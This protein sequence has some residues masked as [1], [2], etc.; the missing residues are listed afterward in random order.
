MIDSLSFTLIC[1]AYLVW[2]AWRVFIKDKGS[3]GGL[4]L[5]FGTIAWFQIG[6]WLLG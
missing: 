1:V 3:P 4:G 6:A 5:T 2:Y